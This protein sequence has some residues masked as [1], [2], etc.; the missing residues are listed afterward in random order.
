LQLHWPHSR[1]ML[2]VEWLPSWPQII[3]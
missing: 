2:Q 1:K 3:H